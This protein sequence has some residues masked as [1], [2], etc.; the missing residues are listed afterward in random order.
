[1]RFRSGPVEIK[2]SIFE[3]NYIGMRAYRGNA[4]ISDNIITKNEIGIFV[5]EKGGGLTITHN[6]LFGNSGYNIRVGDFNDEDVSA[7][8][9]W[10]GYGAP[11]D[12]LF[13]GRTEPGIGKVI[14]EPYLK[15]PVETG[16]GEIK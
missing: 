15:A 10:W 9:N 5:R 7:P 3:G 14:Y 11:A 1:M 6:N 12:K 8:G 4:V 16:R 13:D 2:R